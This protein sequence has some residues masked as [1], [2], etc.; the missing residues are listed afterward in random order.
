MNDTNR[1]KIEDLIRQILVYLGENPDREGLKGTP[2]R[3]SRMYKEVFRGYKSELPKITTFSN[4]TDG[5]TYD[6]MIVDQGDFYSHCLTGDSQV[7][8]VKGT[9]RIKD[10]AGKKEKVYCYDEENKR[11]T[12]SDATNIRKTRKNTEVWK[13]TTDYNVI[14]ATPDHKFL[15]YNRGWIQLKDLQPK[16]SL[17]ALNTR[18]YDDYLNIQASH[19]KDGWK[20]EHNFIYEEVSKIKLKK[21]ELVHHIDY[22]KRNN[23]IS[24]LQ[25]LTN[26]E[27]SSLHAKEFQESLSLEEK[28]ENGKRA[29]RGFQN[30]QN[31]NPAKYKKVKKKATNSL[32]SF[33][34]TEAGNKLKEDKSK[35]MQKEWKKRKEMNNHKVVKV[36]FYGKEDVYNMEVK[37]YKNFVANGLVVHNCEHHMVPFFGKYYFAYIPDKTILGLSKVARVVE[38]FSAKLQIQERLV[39]VIVDALESACQPRGMALIMKGEHLCKE[40]R[41]V[42]NKGVMITSELRGVF[43]DEHKVRQEF[44]DLINLKANIL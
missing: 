25:K 4:D 17:V 19:L 21:G 2:S 35:F 6:Q 43:K 36:E 34:Q 44:L 14:Y 30:L 15:T 7:K 31:S 41:G 20:K 22:D 10:L 37:K 32:K 8:T 40:M 12:I 27:H 28:S 1:L 39:K 9:F 18:L 5:I 16:D 42:K 23:S 29:N 26:K 13:L 11:F 24:N 38:H 33:Y 3:V